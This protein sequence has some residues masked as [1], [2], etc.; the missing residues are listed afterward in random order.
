MAL[1]GKNSRKTDSFNFSGASASPSPSVSPDE[2]TKN[3]IIDALRGRELKFSDVSK[4][5]TQALRLGFSLENW[6]SIQVFVFVDDDGT[7]YQIRSG[8]IMSVPAGKTESILKV[9]ND[10]NRRYRWLRFYLD[11]DNDLMAQ[12]DIDFKPADAPD[13]PVLAI[14]R[15]ASILDDVYPEFMKALWA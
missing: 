1:F 5:G 6:S 13:F 15:A 14:M 11:G 12:E 7:S 3:L 8:V 10:V 4:D 9:V 2:A